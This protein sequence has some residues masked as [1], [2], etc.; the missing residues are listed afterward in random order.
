MAASSRHSAI[1]TSSRSASC[2]VCLRGR[3]AKQRGNCPAWQRPLGRGPAVAATAD[4]ATARPG[5]WRR[6]RIPPG[7]GEA[8]SGTGSGE[9][10]VTA[11]R[12]PVPASTSSARRVGSGS[13]LTRTTSSSLTSYARLS[14][15]SPMRAIERTESLALR[16]GG[17]QPAPGRPDGGDLPRRDSPLRGLT[18]R[19]HGLLRFPSSAADHH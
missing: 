10:S 17:H 6:P 18:R 2:A 12:N 15:P 3:C 1:G 5:S 8:G 19:P 16:H 7:I 4:P 13:L 11:A 9:I 14:A